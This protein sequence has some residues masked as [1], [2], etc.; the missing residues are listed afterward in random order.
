MASS[1]TAYATGA[2]LV[3]YHDVRRIGDLISDTDTRVVAASVPD[4]P[5]VAIMLKRASGE[6]EMACQVGGKYSPEAL[7]ALDGVA[8]EALKGLVC[9]LAAW[10]LEKRRSRSVKLDDVPGAAEAYGVLR[11]LEEGALVFPT[12][13][14]VDATGMEVV[15]NQAQTEAGRSMADGRYGDTVGGARRFFGR[16]LGERR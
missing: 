13:E 5:L 16:R 10:H 9:D 15:E 7:A 4:H 2:D 1:E 14:A 3:L 11:A 12:D 8:A 6:V